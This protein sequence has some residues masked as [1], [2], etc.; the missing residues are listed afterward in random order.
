MSGVQDII[1]AEELAGEKERILKD[2]GV[3]IRD[4]EHLMYYREFLRAFPDGLDGKD[5]RGRLPCVGCGYEL[6][7]DKAL[8]CRQ[9][10]LLFPPQS[11]VC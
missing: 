6:K 5:R 9:L 2:D 11:A 4:E 7:H 10:P 3:V 8:F 1:C